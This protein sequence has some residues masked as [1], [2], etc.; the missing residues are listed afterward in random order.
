M[1]PKRPSTQRNR[2]SGGNKGIGDRQPVTAEPNRK[3]P[4]AKSEAE[5]KARGKA[6][7]K[8]LSS[9]ADCAD[10]HR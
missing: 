3:N 5:A 7:G 1:K 4:A 10:H 9:A 8:K 2:G 6:G